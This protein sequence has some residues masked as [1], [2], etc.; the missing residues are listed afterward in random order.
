MT[1]KEAPVIIEQTFQVSKNIIWDAIT[2]IEK[3]KIWFFEN[4][5]EFKHEIGFQTKFNVVSGDRNFM[6]CWKITQV[7]TLKKITYHWNYEGYK[8]DSYV[9]FE[10]FT[11][12]NN[13]L[14]RV[15]TE[16]IEDF[17]DDII[18]F[19]RES[20]IGGWNYFIK[21]RLKN[22]IKKTTK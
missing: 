1:S 19:K 11:K 9:Y 4:I 21:D 13:T 14:L 15:T 8:G 22:Y 6:H 17:N 18:E 3:M 2:N 20:C 5:E 7:E 10:L 12:E 16:V